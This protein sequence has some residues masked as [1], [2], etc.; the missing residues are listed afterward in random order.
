MMTLLKRCSPIRPRCNLCAALAIMALL[1]VSHGTLA[2]QVD[3]KVYP[4]AS[5]QPTSHHAVVIAS[6]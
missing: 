4:G 2:Q 5:C 1:S 6:S 3:T